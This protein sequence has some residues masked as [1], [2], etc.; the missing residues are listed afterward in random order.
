MK[1]IPA[2]LAAMSL[3]SVLVL[4]AYLAKREARRKR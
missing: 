3:A 1:R 2:V 4:A